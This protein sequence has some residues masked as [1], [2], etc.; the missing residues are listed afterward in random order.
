MIR[1]NTFNRIS[2]KCEENFTKHVKLTLIRQENTT[3][4]EKYR[5]QARG[6]MML[7]VKASQLEMQNVLEGKPVYIVLT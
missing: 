2:K 3:S 7:H 4:I 5:E 6:N 1:E